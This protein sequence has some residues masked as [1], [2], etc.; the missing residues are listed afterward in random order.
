MLITKLKIVQILI[1]SLSTLVAQAGIILIYNVYA[2]STIPSS[3]LMPSPVNFCI[4]QRDLCLEMLTHIDGCESNIGRVKICNDN[5][6]YTTY[7]GHC[8]CGSYMLNRPAKVLI[9]SQLKA[10]AS[11]AMVFVW[12][13]DASSGVNSDASCEVLI[14][15]TKSV[16]DVF[17]CIFDLAMYST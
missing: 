15:D 17:V 6:D 7:L 10:N 1:L 16:L 3:V 14:K 11:N 13:R 5:N 4:A 8:S 12:P 9:E 2:W